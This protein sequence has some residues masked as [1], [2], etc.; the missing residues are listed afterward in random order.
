MAYDRGDIRAMHYNS[1]VI[2]RPGVARTAES[3][4]VDGIV[5]GPFFDDPSVADGQYAG[6]AI[7]RP[8]VAD[9]NRI[10]RASVVS[11]DKLTFEGDPYTDARTDL[12]Y[13][14]VGH[15]D[16]DVINDCIRRCLRHIHFQYYWPLGWHLDNDFA[17]SSTTSPH[18][19]TSGAVNMTTIEKIT[20]GGVYT[21]AGQTGPRNLR[22]TG[23]AAGNGYVISSRLNVTEGDRLFH[24]AIARVNGA[25]TGSY[26]L[27]DVTNGAALETV[28]F[29][30][31]SF[32]RIAMST[33][34]P[35]G[36]QQ[37]EVRIGNVTASGVTEWDCLFG[38]LE[39]VEFRNLILPSW[40]TRSYQFLQIGPA[41][42][43]RQTGTDL[44]NATSRQIRAWYPNLEYAPMP[45]RGDASVTNLQINRA[46]GLPST[47]L[48][49]L[50]KRPW[51]TV[52]DL[53]DES[54]TTEAEEE[55]L[56]YAF[57][58]ELLSVLH[59]ADKNLDGVSE[60]LRSR[61]SFAQRLAAEKI[62]DIAPQPKRE[63]PV[64]H[65]GMAG[66]GRSRR[67]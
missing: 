41:N 65:I 54:E 25:Y 34:I 32:Q 6:A 2:P 9:P 38:H 30:D 35:S 57:Y 17:S 51:S 66:R 56:M 62:A 23:S 36:C 20:T 48:W 26:V 49:I 61:D 3:I 53:S 59:E 10:K 7:Y 12:A 44:W 13:E 33:A 46:G 50:A 27:Y 55:Q 29:T 4:A 24:G 42:Y 52:D 19:W 31:R 64:L 21:Q 14:I 37:V 18:D 39:G 45:L 28:T 40:L 47:D 43:G 22:L 67:W 60:W 11:D 58:Y 5:D 16:P 15:L 8:G 1:Q 63:Q